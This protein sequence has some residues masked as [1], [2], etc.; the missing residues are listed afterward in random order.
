MTYSQEKYG[1]KLVLETKVALKVLVMFIPIPMFWALYM[2]QTSRF[3]FQAT[4]MNGDLGFYTIK[5]DQMILLNSVMG[6]IMIPYFERF[7]YAQMEKIG[8]KTLLHRLIFGNSCT[9]LAF[10]VAA[11]VEMQVNQREISMLW[12]IPQFF[13]L[14]VG[15][16]FVYVGH[17]NFAY[18]EAPKSMKPVMVA[19][20]YFTIAL[21]GF[22]VA[23]V[24]GV[25]LFQSQ[26][27]EYFF[28]AFLMV[29]D[30]ALLSFLTYRYKYTDH[31]MIKALEEEEKNSK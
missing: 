20:F 16:I 3:I 28:F 2:Q 23:I 25:S 13:I 9:I 4:R 6:L 5:P 14:A 8:I 22:F 15:E 31:E 12:Q 11:V 24:S 29:L 21:G 1:R 7:G 27:I 10:I 18:K 17:L 19:F 30:V 26:V